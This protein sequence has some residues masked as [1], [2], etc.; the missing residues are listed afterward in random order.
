MFG[1]LAKFKSAD[2][3]YACLMH[4]FDLYSS[5]KNLYVFCYNEEGSLCSYNVT[6]E[7]AE[8]LNKRGEYWGKYLGSDGC[9]YD[10]DKANKFC[11]QYWKV[12]DWE[13]LS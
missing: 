11:E 10:G 13:V 1:N 3:M 12:D 9:I 8:K 4:S 7:Q 6:Q 5:K 2:E